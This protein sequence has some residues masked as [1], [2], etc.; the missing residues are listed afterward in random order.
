MNNKSLFKNFYDELY[1]DI[2]DEYYKEIDHISQRNKLY[3]I[4]SN[5]IFSILPTIL[6]WIFFFKKE[7]LLLFIAVTIVYNIG[8]IIFIKVLYRDNNK[9]IIKEIK[10]KILDDIITLISS[11]EEARVLPNNRI[12]KDSF[13]KTEL[14]NLE[15]INYTG[16]NFIQ[17]QLDDRTVIMA[18]MN[19]YTFTEKY[20]EEYFYIG[21][22]KF[23]RSYK[24]KIKKDI[25]NGCYIG[26]EINRNNDILIQMVPNRI[27]DKTINN[28]INRY[29]D[30]K[31]HEIYLENDELSKKYTVYSNDEIK[32]RMILTLPMM[33]KINELDKIIKN[34]KYIIFKPDG[35]YAIFIEGITFE[36]ILDKNLYIKRN[37]KEF[38]NI[39]KI[40]EEIYKLY[41]I[42]N[43]M[44]NSR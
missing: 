44:N 22:R 21:N 6:F 4:F 28:K 35:R 42:V 11:D 16:A 12:S 43:V 17:S 13:E 7:Y 40:Y 23:L 14:F 33:E 5:I 39:Y 8:I 19:I 9:E 18:D 3:S 32:T 15:E 31:G 38:D 41:E 1:R 34:K 10:Y 20:K 29:F 27:K 2:L 25:F 37:D 36:N 24:T 26:S 30:I